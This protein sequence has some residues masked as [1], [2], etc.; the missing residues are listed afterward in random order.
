VDVITED[1]DFSPYRFLVAPAYQL[2]D[3]ELVS[4][5][6]QFAE[7]GGHVVLSARTGQKDRRGQLWEG[8]WAMPILDLIGARIPVY[9]VLPAPIQGN[10]RAGD[11]MYDW[12]TWADLLEPASGT[13]VLATYADQYYAGKAAAVSRPLGNGSVTYVGVDS[14]DGSLEKDLLRSVFAR[15]GVSAA[16][17]PSQFIVDW[18]DGFWIATNFTSIRQRVPLGANQRLLVGKAELDPGGVAVWQ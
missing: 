8:P 18:R 15:A 5:F 9:D 16:D 6:R 13:T 3:Q 1:K 17:Y 11:K 12:Y 2:L 7:R 10:V 14:A 4:R